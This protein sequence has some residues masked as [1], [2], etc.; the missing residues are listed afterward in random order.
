MS[1]G[2]VTHVWMDVWDSMP[3]ERDVLCVNLSRGYGR[4]PYMVTH[5]LL[6]L[7]GYLDDDFP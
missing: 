2:I 4:S 3:V 1:S 5:L 6:I 7:I